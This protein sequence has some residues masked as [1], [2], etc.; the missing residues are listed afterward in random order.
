MHMAPSLDNTFFACP[1]PMSNLPFVT[2][3]VAG[4][5]A[6]SA[7]A[8]LLHEDLVVAQ[9]LIQ[10][11]TRGFAVRHVAD[12]AEPSEQ[13]RLLT[14][15]ELRSVAQV[16][17]TG[18]FR[19]LKSAPN[20]S[21]GWKCHASDLSLLGEA[22]D[23]LY[24]GAIADWFAA[25]GS[26]P[27]VTHYREFTNRQSGMYRITRMLD[28]RSVSQ[29]ISA[30]CDRSFC[31]KQRLWT[32]EGHPTDEASAKSLIPCLEPCPVFLELARTAWRLEQTK[33]LTIQLAPRDLETIRAALVAAREHPDANEREAD[34][35]SAANPRRIALLLEKL[36]GS[37]AGQ[38]EGEQG[39]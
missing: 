14:I 38:G 27:P 18:A 25:R 24:P 23:S 26:A 3:T 36:P 1:L 15:A 31:L 17:S 30:C 6:L 20:L 16:T 32:V 29:V 11:E 21:R 34:F 33:D 7:F 8:A 10:T 39:D 13:L 9:V 22:L 28:S 19:P 12:R 4:D 37:P 35:T 5:P 2:M